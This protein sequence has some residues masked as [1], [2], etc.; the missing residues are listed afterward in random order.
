LRPRNKKKLLLPDSL[1]IPPTCSRTSDDVFNTI[2]VKLLRD[3]VSECTSPAEVTFA[4]D[5]LANTTLTML[6]KRAAV[7]G[8]ATSVDLRLPALCRSVTMAKE[9]TWV[10]F[11]IISSGTDWLST[12]KL[13]QILAVVGFAV[14]LELGATV[15]TVGER[16]GATEGEAV[17]LRVGELEGLAVG[18]RVSGEEEG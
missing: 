11:A 15:G 7:K 5:P 4:W 10:Q 18:V 14:G 9:L 16:V 8:F 2:A 13:L 12:Q 6:V 17:G 1:S 3:T